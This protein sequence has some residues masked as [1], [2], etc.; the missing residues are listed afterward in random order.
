LLAALGCGASRPS[1]QDGGATHVVGHPS[2]TGAQ[3]GRGKHSRPEPTAA[4][5]ERDRALLAGWSSA[6]PRAFARKETCARVL[7]WVRWPIGP[8]PFTCPPCPD[9]A[10]C[11]PCDLP[12]IVLVDEP[13]DAAALDRAALDGSVSM[14]QVARDTAPP[15]NGA[16]LLEGRWANPLLF[17]VLAFVPVTAGPPPPDAPM[18][19]FCRER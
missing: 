11:E 9:G 5:R 10:L 8:E 18:S 14:A 15:E 4:E 17:E 7:G 2:P 19:D 3:S 12:W 6:Y 1:A 16:Y 13:T